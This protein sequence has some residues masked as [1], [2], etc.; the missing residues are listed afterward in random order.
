[1]RKDD[2]Q[3]FANLL[4]VY[5]QR[6][7]AYTMQDE[8][9]DMW[10]DRLK[11]ENFN[12]TKEVFYDLIGEKDRPFGWKTVINRLDMKFPPED[13]QKRFEREW[14]AKAENVGSEEKRKESAAFMRGLIT[15]IKEAR[16]LNKDFD[17]VTPY[18]QN[19]IEVFGREE[20]GRIARAMSVD[21][22]QT[23]SEAKFL[24]A[25]QEG[26]R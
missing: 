2:K 9:K 10:W 25:V 14:K 24:D 26:L 21:V 3:E 4:K 12:H 7:G 16:R 23:P 22:G 11:G 19:F 5:S 6:Y 13:E 15:E 17:W 8:T 18:A 20:A 1:V